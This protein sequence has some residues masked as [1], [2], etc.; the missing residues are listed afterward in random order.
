MKINRHDQA[1]SPYESQLFTVGEICCA[2]ALYLAFVFG[3]GTGSLE[4]A[5]ST[6]PM[7][8]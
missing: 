5:A 1:L 3:Y 2:T 4:V 6:A 7:P 8:M